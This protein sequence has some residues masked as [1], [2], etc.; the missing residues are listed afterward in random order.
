MGAVTERGIT[1][2]L[3]LAKIGGAGF[4]G[5]KG[6]RGKAAALVRPVTEGLARGMATGAEKILLTGFKLNGSGRKG[7]NLRFAHDASNYA[8]WAK[9]LQADYHSTQKCPGRNP[10][11]TPS[12]RKTYSSLGS[13]PSHSICPSITAISRPFSLPLALKLLFFLSGETVTT[14]VKSRS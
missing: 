5:R 1:G 12:S 10:G 14:E 4:L 8:H 9:P 2:V 11:A 3:A 13:S 6:L 7:G